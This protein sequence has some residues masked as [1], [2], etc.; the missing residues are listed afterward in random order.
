MKKEIER[1][2]I[3]RITEDELEW[4]Y[5]QFREWY[6]SEG[7]DRMYAIPLWVA[8][9]QEVRSLIFKLF[10]EKKRG[11]QCQGKV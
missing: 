8:T 7:N 4:A 9:P 6:T 11:E 2:R 10:Q 3:K 5:E 1:V